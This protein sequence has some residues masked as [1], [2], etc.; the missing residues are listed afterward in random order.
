M[1]DSRNPNEIPTASDVDPGPGVST[2]N[3][4]AVGQT[5]GK[6]LIEKSLG[7][8]G[9][10]N[11]F[12]AYD[13]FGAAG[14][15]ALKVARRSVPDK[16][17]QAWTQAEAEPLVKL[18]HPNIVR[19]VD[20]GCVNGTPYVATQLVEGL[21]L[22]AH[23]KNNIPSI[24][25]ILDWMIQLVGAVAYTHEQGIIHRDLKP[26][27]IIVTPQGQPR[28]IDLGIS[29]LIDAY[30][31][32]Y[33]PRSS[34][35]VFFMP[36]EQASGD[37]QADHRVDL[38]A[39]GGILKFLLM[40]VGPYGPFEEASQAFKDIFTGGGGSGDLR[41]RLQVH[42]ADNVEF[43]AEGDG[44]PMRRA[45]ALIANRALSVDPEKRFPN[46]REM[47]R[48]LGCLR[49]RRRFL[50][51]GAAVVLAAIVIVATAFLRHNPQ[52][53]G[54]SGPPTASLEVHF[55]R[56][57]QKGSY[58][59]LAPDLLP[60]RTGDKIQIHAELSE[61][62]AVYLVAVDPDGRIAVLYPS[63]GEKPQPT[64]KIDIPAGRNQWLPLADPIGT[65][66]I[67]LLARREPLEKLADLKKELASF[68][69][70][71]KV[72]G[73]GLLVAGEKGVQL[74]HH[75]AAMHRSI[76]NEVVNEEKGMLAGLLESVPRKWM[77]VRA[78][79]FPHASEIN[80]EDTPSGTSP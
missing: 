4:P 44:P 9:Q 27:N 17:A 74:L 39:L 20:A 58:Q 3:L 57:D 53:P 43:V 56:A 28:I 64:R 71:P 42:M 21:P 63:E 1:A 67:L 7:S 72:K 69:P 65:E 12:Q 62:L 48:S 61:A 18:E 10:A 49:N 25:Q 70:A 68:G 8:G 50:A 41:Q 14:H 55:Q 76:S 52:T 35:T 37:P 38:F 22:S 66:T 75:D 31:P 46:A 45:L 33:K 78:I 29:S 26:S 19:V 77:F 15:V 2:G 16:K 36:P 6:Y 40:G 34:G 23:V 47:L 11:V 13:R 30:Q 24:R 59:M 32:E 79:S 73:L 5:W 80:E 51:T 54:P 60:L